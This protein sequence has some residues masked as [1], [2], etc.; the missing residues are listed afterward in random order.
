MFTKQNLLA[1]LAGFLVMFFLGYTIWG[2]ATEDFFT[3]HTL[4]NFMKQP[5]KKATKI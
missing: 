5:P 2:F 1:S 3:G 4:N